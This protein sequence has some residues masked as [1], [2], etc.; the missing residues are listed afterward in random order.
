M[1]GLLICALTGVAAAV[2]AVIAA[3]I[4][5]LPPRP[6]PPRQPRA[7]VR[8]APRLMALTA[9]ARFVKRS[10]CRVTIGSVSWTPAWQA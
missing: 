1:L 6:P 5:V 9:R 10:E 7:M 3:W 2:L 4:G 8:T